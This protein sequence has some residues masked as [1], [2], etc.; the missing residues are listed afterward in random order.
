MSMT[1]PD[2]LKMERD[3]YLSEPEE[4]TFLGY[5][6]ECGE[7][8]TDEYAHVR[9]EEGLFFCDMECVKKY[10]GLKEMN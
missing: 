8:I 5:C 2:I 6:E 3:G 4:Y 7:E 9:Q 10:Y 1:H